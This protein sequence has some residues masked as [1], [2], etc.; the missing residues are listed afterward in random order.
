MG[1]LRGVKK[2]KNE[3]IAH[4]RETDR[5]PQTV[6]EHLTGVSEITGD[7]AAKIGLKEAGELIGLMHDIGKASDEFQNYIKSATGLLDPDRDDFV[8]I[9]NMRGKIDHSSAGAQLL[10]SYLNKEGQ[11]VLAAQFL[12]LCIA[13]HHSGLI[14]CISPDGCDVFS[15]RME[16]EEDLTHKEKAFSK[17]NRVEQQKILQRINDE[18]I[19]ISIVDKLKSLRESSDTKDTLAFKFG[20]LIRFMF[21]CL[22]DAD[23]LD[24]ADFEHPQNRE[25]RNYGEYEYWGKLV[26]RLEKKIK[27]FSE[28]KDKNDVDELRNQVSQSCLESASKSRGFFQLSVPTGGG[29]TLSSLRFALHHA[30]TWKMDRIFYIIPYTS[31]IDQNADEIRKVLE[32]KDE[33]GKYLNNI[34][35]EH[36]SNLTPDEESYRQKLLSQNWDAPVVLTTQ[37]QFLEAL[38]GSGTGNARRMHQLANSVIVFD[39]IQ[40][41]PL[42]CVHM[43]NVAVRFLVNNCGCT[44]IMC[45]ATQ[46]LLDKVEPSERSLNIPIENRIIRDEKS[47][48]TKLKRTEILDRRKAGGWSID[49]VANLALSEI[50]SSGSVLIIVNTRKSARMLYQVLEKLYYGKL[51]HLSTNMCPAHRLDVLSEL[52]KRL[53]ENQPVICISTQLIEAGVDIDFGSVIRYFAGLDSIAQAAGRCNRNGRREIGNVWIVNP[54]DENLDRL[55]DIRIGKEKAMKVFDEFIIDP[56]KFNNDRIGPELISEYYRNYYY[57]RQNIM[58]YPVGPQTSVGHNDDLFNLLSLNTIS[59]EGFVHNNHEINPKIPFRQSFQS[60]SRA[61]RVI[62]SPTRGVITPYTSFGEKI[63]AELCGEPFGNSQFYWMKQAQ[64]YSVNMFSN[65]FESLGKSGAIKEVRPESGIFYLNKQYYSQNF[66]WCEEPEK[67]MDNLIY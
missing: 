2:M 9:E 21:S 18:R 40:T 28:K 15:R 53:T 33:S 54:A 34:V 44:V 23:R 8:D 60:A 10:Y 58:M 50:D 42:P 47:I 3:M 65:Y 49:E 25:M 56:A 63:I 35:L 30:E 61:F 26:D 24:T 41:I 13:S 27:E 48:F 64:R 39:E 62:D 45:T 20:L 66:G 59:V 57:E 55:I 31:I 19:V 43:F 6:W 67:P 52:K 17:L 11:S 16:K 5:V 46:P 4:L 37:V 36:H 7:F 32:D 1:F 38:F 51:F 29:K 22:I 12:S 14:D